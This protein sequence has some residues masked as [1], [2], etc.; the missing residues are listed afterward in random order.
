MSELIVRATA[1]NADI[2]AAAKEMGADIID[3]NPTPCA[4][5]IRE[6]PSVEDYIADH[7]GDNTA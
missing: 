4:E 5:A 2:L 1:L 3:V 6:F 7:A